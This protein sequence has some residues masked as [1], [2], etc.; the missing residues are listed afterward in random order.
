MNNISQQKHVG[1]IVLNGLETFF[2]HLFI[3]LNVNSFQHNVLL[4]RKE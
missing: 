3:Y 4:K 1:G 2:H